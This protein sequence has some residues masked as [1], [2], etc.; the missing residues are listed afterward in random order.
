MIIHVHSETIY[1][2]MFSG[3]GSIVRICEGMCRKR[4]IGSCSVF[5]NEPF[6]YLTCVQAVFRHKLHAIRNSNEK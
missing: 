1:D 6:K 3:S 2:E 4:K 5:K